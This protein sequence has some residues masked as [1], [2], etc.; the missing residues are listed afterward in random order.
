V[1]I[2]RKNDKISKVKIKKSQDK[3]GELFVM[4]INPLGAR[5]VVVLLACFIAIMSVSSAFADPA[6]WIQGTPTSGQFN[7]GLINPT[8]P[9]ISE[10]STKLYYLSSSTPTSRPWVGLVL[11]GTGFEPNRSVAFG[12]VGQKGDPTEPWGTGTV[13]LPAPVTTDENGEFEYNVTFARASPSS[14]NKFDGYGGEKL[15]VYPRY[16]ENAGDGNPDGRIPGVQITLTIRP[17]VIVLPRILDTITMYTGTDYSFSDSGE[18]S[19]VASTASMIIDDSSRQVRLA[20]AGMT[21]RGAGNA[22]LPREG[23]GWILPNGVMAS[24]NADSSYLILR[25]PESGVTEGLSETF[26]IFG[27]GASVVGDGFASVVGFPKTADT[28][29]ATF[30]LQVE[31]S[32]RNITPNFDLVTF[33][34]NETANAAIEFA[35]NPPNLAI[36]DLKIVDPDT[37]EKVSSLTVLGGLVITAAPGRRQVSFSGVP[38]LEEGEGSGSYQV[39]W[40]TTDGEEISSSIDV[41]VSTGDVYVPGHNVTLIGDG[42]PE[43]W[44]TGKPVEAT[45]RKIWITRNSEMV[46]VPVILTVDSAELDGLNVAAADDNTGITITGA[47]NFSGEKTFYV[48]VALDPTGGVSGTISPNRV[49]F[50]VFADDADYQL[51]FDTK[52]VSVPVGKEMSANVN[53]L[54][55]PKYEKDSIPRAFSLSVDGAPLS[56]EDGSWHWNGLKITDW[57]N[58]ATWNGWLE[59]S[60][61]AEQEGSVEFVYAPTRGDN[62]SS[63]SFTIEA[64]KDEDIEDISETPESEAVTN[65]DAP[66]VMASDDVRIENPV[67]GETT[68]IIYIISDDVGGVTNNY[69]TNN[70]VNIQTVNLQSPDGSTIPLANLNDNTVADPFRGTPNSYYFDRVNKQV[71]VYVTP[72]KAGDYVCHIYYEGR[73]PTKLNVHPVTLPVTVTKEYYNTKKESG[74]G[75]CDAGTSAGGALLLAV[76]ALARRKR[77]K[78]SDRS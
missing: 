35:A 37:G 23:N 75:G 10:A 9:G 17:T 20:I 38:S 68:K 70:Y 72:E 26:S 30:K 3:K 45:Q 69:T 7:N 6:L 48:N 24:S 76:I 43:F 73:D 54:V 40:I 15:I 66:V 55:E 32:G 61:T 11:R 5:V 64:H 33:T 29:I 67:A 49:S 41:D 31:K 12:I 21:L 42:D 25:T 57:L 63:T 58:T 77:A 8:G 44:Q 18:D 27:T 50:T 56:N 1:K 71:I 53:L 65:P 51:D 13:S 52:K 78:Q 47:P 62:M 14:Y 22:E 36:G 59:I 46:D 60:G 34:N 19:G 74:G 39:V 28:Q 4:K 2:Q 16:P